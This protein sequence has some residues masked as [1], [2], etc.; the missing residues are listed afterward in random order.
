M[1]EYFIGEINI[2][3]YVEFH[4]NTHNAATGAET[5]ADALPTY[6]IY[7]ENNDTVVSVG[8]MAKRDDANT[9]G[10]YFARVQLTTAAGYEAGKLYF[11]R[12]NGIVDSIASSAVMVFRCIDVATDN[13]AIADAL[14]DEPRA[15]HTG[16]GTFG[17]IVRPQDNYA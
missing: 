15:G 3:D 5:D 13:A 4:V 6:R 16:A 7:E 2:D 17:K 10:Y 11:V 14:W 8:D 1:S 9:T 12:L